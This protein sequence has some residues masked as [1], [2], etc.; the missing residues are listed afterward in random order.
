MDKDVHQEYIIED[1]IE[2]YHLATP[3]DRILKDIV[4]W[5]DLELTIKLILHYLIVRRN[6]QYTYKCDILNN[7]CLI[8]QDTRYRRRNGTYPIILTQAVEAAIQLMRFY[9]IIEYQIGPEKTDDPMWRVKPSIVETYQ[10][11][12]FIERR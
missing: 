4:A 1:L 2:E 8:N 11:I 3:L 12:K 9:E 6:N 7:V 10:L 5:L